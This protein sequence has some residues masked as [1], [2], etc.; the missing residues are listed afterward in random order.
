MFLIQH[1]NLRRKH[2]L[3]KLPFRFWVQFFLNSSH[4]LL[5]S[6]NIYIDISNTMCV[7]SF[8]NSLTSKPF[9]LKI[10]TSSQ[11]HTFLQINLIVKQVMAMPLCASIYFFIH[12]VYGKCSQII[13]KLILALSNYKKICF[14]IRSIHILVPVVVPTNKFCKTCRSFPC[15]VVLNS[16]YSDGYVALNS[17]SQPGA[18]CF[19][20]LQPVSVLVQK[21]VAI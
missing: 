15:C 14:E 20:N 7:N 11:R 10:N 1:Y 17:V 18:R 21:E 4:I 2:V 19:C 6:A 9:S 3:I 12:K 16:V 13:H 5:R 8:S